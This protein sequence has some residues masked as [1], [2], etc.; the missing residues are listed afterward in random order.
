MAHGLSATLVAL[1]PLTILA[2]HRHGVSLVPALP[3]LVRPMFGAALSATV[4]LLLIEPLAGAG[5]FVQLSVAG[6]AGCGIFIIVVV[7]FDEIRR[8]PSRLRARNANRRGAR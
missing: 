8:L 2:L 5:A 7:P 3:G 4:I 6:G 1:P